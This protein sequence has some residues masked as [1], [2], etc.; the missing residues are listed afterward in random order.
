MFEFIESISI[1]TVAGSAR[2]RASVSAKQPLLT[3]H[4]PGNPLLPGSW[5]IELVAQIA[6]PLAEEL[7]RQ[8]FNLDRWALMG[9]IRDAK[10]LRP[11]S[12]PAT[13]NLFARAE[14]VETS[15]VAV[16][17]SAEVDDQL[18]M[19]AELVMMMAEAAPEW[20]QAIR[21]REARLARWKGTE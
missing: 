15:S 13:I 11:V 6:G 21:A 1:D 20:H 8:N 3:D 7:V 4:F 17:V 2:G 5:L 9:M 18:V 19:R 10:F 14:R 16:S 12:W